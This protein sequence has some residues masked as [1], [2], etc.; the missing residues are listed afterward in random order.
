MPPPSHT[1]L[2]L[3]SFT[4]RAILLPLGSRTVDQLVDSTRIDEE[5]LLSTLRF[6]VAR[7]LLRHLGTRTYI[8]VDAEEGLGGHGSK[9]P[10]TLNLLEG[11]LSGMEEDEKGEEEEDEEGKRVR[12]EAIL[13]EGALRSLGSLEP[14]LLRLIE[15]SPF[16]ILKTLHA[17]IVTNIV[18]IDPSLHNLSEEKVE[19]YLSILIRNKK[20]KRGPQGAYLPV[21]RD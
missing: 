10:Y 17:Y 2:Y 15:Q 16:L 18:R 7:G 9:P 12:D 6:W 5:V 14:D 4:H 1:P 21:I 3:L 19:A 8:P 13:G 20:I 11:M